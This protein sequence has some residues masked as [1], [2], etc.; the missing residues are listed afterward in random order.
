MKAFFVAAQG[1][2]LLMILF[3]A[4][5]IESPSM[6]PALMMAIGSLLV[7]AGIKGEKNYVSY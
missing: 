5:A 3:G 6:I 2:G 1:L 7:F 4:A